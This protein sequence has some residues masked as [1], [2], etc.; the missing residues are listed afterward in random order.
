MGDFLLEATAELYDGLATENLLDEKATDIL[1]EYKQFERVPLICRP[2]EESWLSARGLYVNFLETSRAVF[3]PQFNLPTDDK[4]ISIM[5]KY[6]RKP[7]VRV[8]CTQMARYG[9]AVHCLTREYDTEF[10]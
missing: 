5:E 4:V 1:R 2:D 7:L 9:G 10:I 3:V 8:D 6:T